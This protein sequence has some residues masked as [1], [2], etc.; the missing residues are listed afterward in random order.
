MFLIGL[1]GGIGAGKSTIARRLAEH[2]ATVLDADQVA[3]EAV[4]PNSPALTQLVAAFGTD[5]LRRDGELNR[6]QLAKKVFGQPE[7]LQRLNEI[8]HP[9]VR[10]L[11]AQRLEQLRITN[12]SGVVVYDVPLLIEASVN[13]DWDLIVVAIADE[14]TR[15]KRLT[16]ERG[17]SEDEAR[18]RIAHQASDEQRRAIADVIIDTSGSLQHTLQQT[19]ALW[20]TLEERM[21]RDA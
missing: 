17:M 2:G 18:R 5:I 13:H 4:A 10:A 6:E 14:A 1:T 8:V 21:S 19:D 7:L 20:A 9:A 3:R 15:L 12:P 11:T 16:A